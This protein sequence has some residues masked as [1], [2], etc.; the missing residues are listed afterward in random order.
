LKGRWNGHR[1]ALFITFYYITGRLKWNAYNVT[2]GAA[3]D[4]MSPSFVLFVFDGEL[5]EWLRYIDKIG[6]YIAVRESTMLSILL[7]YKLCLPSM[8]NETANLV[9]CAR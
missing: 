1:F 4:L 6:G 5:H 7:T 8:G 2:L 9:K 3:K